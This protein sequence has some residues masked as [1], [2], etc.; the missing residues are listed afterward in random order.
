MSRRVIASF[1]LLVL[2]LFVIGTVSLLARPRPHD[3]AAARSL[4]RRLPAPDLALAS[5]SRQL[6]MPSLEEQWAPFED[7]PGLLDIDP[8]GGFFRPSTP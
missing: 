1:T 6:R 2:P 8:A 3:L 7:S 5:G 4:A